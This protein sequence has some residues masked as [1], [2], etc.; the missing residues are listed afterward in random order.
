MLD[1]HDEPEFVRCAFLFCRRLQLW[2]CYVALRCVVLCYSG[3][4]THSLSMDV[5]MSR[6]GPMSR[7]AKLVVV[8]RLEPRRIRDDLKQ[9]TLV[10]CNAYT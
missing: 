3:T 10:R 6:Q 7:R 8:W 2:L 4:A 9:M 5:D 1:D